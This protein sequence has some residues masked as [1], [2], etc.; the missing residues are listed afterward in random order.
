MQA[1]ICAVNHFVWKLLLNVI[2]DSPDCHIAVVYLH[3]KFVAFFVGPTFQQV[4]C[5]GSTALCWHSAIFVSIHD[6]LRKYH[7]IHFFL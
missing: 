3:C 4:V 5:A 1:T 7:N 6:D 2:S